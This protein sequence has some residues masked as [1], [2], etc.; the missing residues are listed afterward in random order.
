ME[1][2]QLMRLYKFSQGDLQPINYLKGVPGET[3]L[4]R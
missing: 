3:S 2:F 1:F 4:W